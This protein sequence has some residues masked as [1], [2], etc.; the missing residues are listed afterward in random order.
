[1][2]HYNPIN[3]TWYIHPRVV[4]LMC[5]LSALVWSCVSVWVYERH[6]PTLSKALDSALGCSIYKSSLETLAQTVEYQK[7]DRDALEEQY[8]KDHGMKNAKFASEQA[9]KQAMIGLVK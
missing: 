5:L 9:M 8:I 4:V 6:A 1:M 3:R 7:K 2:K